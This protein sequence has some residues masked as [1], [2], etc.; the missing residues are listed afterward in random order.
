MVGV[1]KL[2]A[3]ARSTGEESSTIERDMEKERGRGCHIIY[4]LSLELPSFVQKTV[5]VVSLLSGLI[6]LISS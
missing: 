2:E 3:W 4:G 1:T 5:T 6:L